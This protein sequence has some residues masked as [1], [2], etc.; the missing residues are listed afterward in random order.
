MLEKHKGPTLGDWENR[1]DAV[2]KQLVRGRPALTKFY[3]QKAI[4]ERYI[5]ERFSSAPSQQFEEQER[6][7][8]GQL[9]A[10]RF[11]GRTDLKLLDLATGPGRLLPCLFPFGATTALD[12]SD[13]ML[14][15]AQRR[16]LPG[17]EFVHGDVFHQSLREKFHVVT[18]GRLL[19]H[20]EY[21]DRRLLYRRFQELLREDGIAIVEAPNRVVEHQLRDLAGWENFS[22]YDVFWTLGEFR[23]ELN[24]NGF[25][26]VSFVS[27]GAHITIHPEQQDTAEPIEY[28]VAFEKTSPSPSQR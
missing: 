24:E 7:A 8:I 5:E 23:E 19:R 14:K 9:I 25:R 2:G 6:C 3:E 13:A 12:G 17:V 4:A 10:S 18:C 21:P 11:G 22:V 26:L 16:S 15:V 1:L 28:V 27:V 20:L